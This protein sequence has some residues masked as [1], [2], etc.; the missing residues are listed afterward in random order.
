MRSAA[1]AAAIA[2]SDG[3]R[4]GEQDSLSPPAL[5][6]RSCPDCGVLAPVPSHRDRWLLRAPHP[7]AARDEP[8][9]DASEASAAR[10]AVAAVRKAPARSPIT[11]RCE[12]FGTNPRDTPAAVSVH[13]HR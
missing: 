5:S 12:V 11:A 6:L 8:T 7:E 1:D 13:G 2:A 10:Q 3:A 9:A 4:G